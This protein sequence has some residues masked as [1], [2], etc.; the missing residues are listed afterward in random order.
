[1]VIRPV[2][3]WSRAPLFC[4]E[5][6]VAVRLGGPERAAGTN[7]S[8]AACAGAERAGWAAAGGFETGA[9]TRVALGGR[10]AVTRAPD[11]AELGKGG[12]MP[13]EGELL[14]TSTYTAILAAFGERVRTSS[15][16]K[17]YTASAG[18]RVQL[19]GQVEE[20]HRL[21]DHLVRPRAEQLVM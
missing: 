17:L 18:E 19:G 1:M 9:D 12:G 13:T 4:T 2:V 8:L 10:G 11:I 5:S 15:D 7:S 3:I 21:G 20:V 6:T 14:L 16:P